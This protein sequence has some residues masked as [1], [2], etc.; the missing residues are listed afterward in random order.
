M[1]RMGFPDQGRDADDPD[2]EVANWKSAPPRSTF[3]AFHSWVNG[4]PVPTELVRAASAGKFW[5]AKVVR[6][7]AHGRVTVRDQYTQPVSGQIT[8]VNAAAHQIAYIVHTGASW[9]GPIG[10]TEIIVTFHRKRMAPPLAPVRVTGA[11]P[12]RSAPQIAQRDWSKE[13]GR[14]FRCSGIQVFRCSGD[15]S[16]GSVGSVGSSTPEH[17]NT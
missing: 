2:E 17:L 8:R 4:E 13:R 7:P 16:V 1:V 10:R 9:H 11:D 5:H 14:V 6:F 15:G 12:A 3:T